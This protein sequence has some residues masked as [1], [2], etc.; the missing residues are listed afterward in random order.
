MTAPALELRDVVVRFGKL[1]AVDGVSFSVAKGE[2]MGIVGESGCGKTTLAKAMVGLNPM[3]AGTMLIDGREVQASERGTLARRVQLL[4][5]DPVASLSPRMRV[6]DLISE[7]LLIRKADTPEQRARLQR[8]VEILGLPSDIASRYAH[9]L[10]GGQARRVSLVRALA[11]EPQALIADEPTAGLDLSV[12]GDVLN[13]IMGVQRD[14]RLTTILISHN[15]NV[16]GRVTQRVAIMYLGKIVEIGETAAVF[17]RPAHPY[18]AALLS[19][20]PVLKGRAQRPR[21]ILSGE[22]PSPLA[23]PPGCRF[24]TRCPIARPRCRVEPPPL[25]PKD[26]DRLAACHYPFELGAAAGPQA[27]GD[28][29]LQ[30]A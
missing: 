9:Q 10:S 24:H 4:F 28:P 21:I 19:A 30:P 15:L 18:T 5:Q 3:A 7:P 16:V 22:Q 2:T 25:A 13:L 14:F 6:G 11:M 23:P 1:V 29:A 12:Q 20:N 27:S 17:R 8:L 26:G